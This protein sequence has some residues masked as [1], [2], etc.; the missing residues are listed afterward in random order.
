M[1]CSAMMVRNGGLW[2]QFCALQEV[3]VS[4]FVGLRHMLLVKRGITATVASRAGAACCAVA[5]GMTAVEF[6]TRHLRA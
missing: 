1:L 6:C 3:E 5:L 2:Q 4:P